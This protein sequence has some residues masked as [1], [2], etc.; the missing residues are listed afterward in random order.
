MHE[1]FRRSRRNDLHIV[2][3]ST[4]RKF[5]NQDTMPM[6]LKALQSTI[7]TSNRHRPR[8]H[9]LRSVF[10]PQ[11]TRVHAIRGRYRLAA[12]AA[13]TLERSDMQTAPKR[14]KDTYAAPATCVLLRIFSH[15]MLHLSGLVATHDTS[16]HP[17]PCCRFAFRDDEDLDRQNSGQEAS[18]S[19][20]AQSLSRGAAPKSGQILGLDKGVWVAAGLLTT[21]ATMIHI[22]VFHTP[23]G[24]LQSYLLFWPMTQLHTG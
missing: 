9:T 3:S 2:R 24:S 11:R 20:Q 5:H 22:T 15:E 17:K 23:L 1:A 13:S 6:Q 21:W 19:S 8:Q 18:I 16:S 12:H 14:A 7:C 4:L 10:A